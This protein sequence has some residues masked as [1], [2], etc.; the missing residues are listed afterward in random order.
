MNASKPQNREQLLGTAPMLPLLLKMSLPAVAAQLVN[1][2]YSMV[3]SIYIGHIPEI[4]TDAL[5]GIGVT[6]SLIILIFFIPYVASG[7]AA[8]G[9]L[10]NSFCSTIA[11]NDSFHSNTR[12]SFL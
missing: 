10:F 9:K 4:G 2:L 3:D 7:L 8:I 6:S 1:L 5:A 12:K 11:D